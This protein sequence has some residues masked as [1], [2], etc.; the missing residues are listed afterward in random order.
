MSEYFFLVASTLVLFLFELLYFRIARKLH[1]IDKPNNRSS[2]SNPTIRGG[3]IIF[4]VAVLIWFVYQNF[5]LP[6]FVTGLTLVTV[7]SFLDD[8]KPRPASLRFMVHTLAVVL[9]FYQVP[10]FDWQWWLVLAALIVC[11]GAL[12]AF[13]FM[14]GING[15]TGIY[16]LVSLGSL[17]WL[18]TNLV[19]FAD[20]RLIFVAIAAVLVFLFFNFRKRAACFAGDVGSITIAFIQIFFLLQLIHTTHHFYWVLLFLVYGLDS[21]VTI[22]SRIRNRENIFKPHR[23]HL[24][25]YLSNELGMTHTHVSLLY[26]TVQLGINIIL[27]NSFTSGSRIGIYVIVPVIVLLYVAARR[28]VL[29]KITKPEA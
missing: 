23:T 7:I 3:G 27:I 28:I 16:A 19:F 12:S 5:S 29:A 1:I 15:I 22:L 24:Y 20:E 17:V 8:L 21:V 9:M 10:L 4:F 18:N 13:N 6:F 26:G 25:Q 14:D 11:I 2:H